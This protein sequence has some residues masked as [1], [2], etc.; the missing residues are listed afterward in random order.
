MKKHMVMPDHKAV[1]DQTIH[2]YP[3]PFRWPVPAIIRNAARENRRQAGTVE[4]ADYGTVVFRVRP[5]EHNP[6][7]NWLDWTYTAKDGAVESGRWQQ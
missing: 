2:N 4:V 5:K 7:E 3:H 6:A 1:L